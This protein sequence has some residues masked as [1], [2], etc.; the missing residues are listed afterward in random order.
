MQ[1]IYLRVI[2]LKCL[3]LVLNLHSQC[4]LFNKPVMK[5]LILVAFIFIAYSLQAQI[6]DN[7]SSAVKMGNASE[8]SNYY[9]STVEIIIDGA[10]KVYTK[11]QAQ[12]VMNDF[13]KKNPPKD[14]E[15]A[16]KSKRE[17]SQ[18]LIGDLKTVTD[19]NYRVIFLLREGSGRTLIHQ[20]R[21]Q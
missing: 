7:I 6:V 5:Q 18:F 21:I 9:N 19:K 13:F 14:F 11:S 17:D 12:M 2:C 16:H 15:I 3:Y 4:R 1:K 8:L 10:D 20:I